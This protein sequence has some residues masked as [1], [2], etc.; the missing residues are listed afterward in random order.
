MLSL[1]FTKG[2]CNVMYESCSSRGF[3]FCFRIITV[4]VSNNDRQKTVS[5]LDYLD[6]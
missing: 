5:K 3:Q 2:I 4:G 1:F 6:G